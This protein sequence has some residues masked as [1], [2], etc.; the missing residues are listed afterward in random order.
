MIA[1]LDIEAIFTQIGLLPILRARPRIGKGTLRTAADAPKATRRALLRFLASDAWEPAAELVDLDYPEVLAW[2]SAGKL[3]PPQVDALFAAVPDKELAQD[4][5]EIADRILPWANGIIPREP[6]DPLT[7]MADEPAP[8]TLLD[9]RRLW[10]VAC[11]PSSIL[12]D[13]ADGSLFDDQVAALAQLF[14]ATFGDTQQAVMDTVSTMVARRG[15]KWKPDP[16]K[17]VLIDT[18]RQRQSTDPGLAAMVQGIYAAQLQ[19][20]EQAAPPPPKRATRAGGGNDSQSTP[21]QEA[22]TG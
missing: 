21:G 18:L 3:Q 7:G 6:P 15:K 13:L 20:E 8:N 19:A 2:V 22:A 16:T 12:D 4:L 10:G 11:N 17:A 9:F 1:A 14:P 5:A